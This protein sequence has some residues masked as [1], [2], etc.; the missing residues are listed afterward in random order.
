MAL[1]RYSPAPEFLH[2]EISRRNAQDSRIRGEPDFSRRIF[3]SVLAAVESDTRADF[4]PDRSG[5]VRTAIG[6]KRMAAS[7]ENI[8][9]RT[10]KE[11]RLDPSACDACI[12][13]CRDD[14]RI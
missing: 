12:M 1:G 14:G 5:Q 10:G 9:G 13:T 4:Q 6:K 11:V 3:P 8:P 2:R 7:G